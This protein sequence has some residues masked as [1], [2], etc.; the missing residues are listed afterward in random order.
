MN[1]T[2]NPKEPLR[3]TSKNRL[4]HKLALRVNGLAHVIRGCDR[5]EAMKPGIWHRKPPLPSPDTLDK[6]RAV[7]TYEEAVD[8]GTEVQRHIR[9]FDAWRRY[10]HMVLNNT[11]K[12][13]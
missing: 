5:V 10:I 13:D 6:L 9:D 11:E 2:W 3:W 12:E 1:F 7:R 8:L 4:Y